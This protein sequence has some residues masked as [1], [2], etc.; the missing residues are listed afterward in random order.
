MPRYSSQEVSSFLFG[1]P[2][3]EA[4][5]RLEDLKKTLPKPERASENAELHERARE[6]ASELSEKTTVRAR[7]CGFPETYDIKPPELP[8]GLTEAHL[9]AI[10]E[11]LA[12]N[13]AGFAERVLPTAADLGGLANLNSGYVKT[14]F[15]ETQRPED[16]ANGLTS[17]RPSWFDATYVASMR[18]ELNALGGSLVLLDTAIKP[19]YKDGSQHYGTPEGNDPAQDPLLPLFREALA[20]PEKP[21]PNRFNHSRDELQNKL[22]PLAKEKIK[23][24]LASRGLPEVDFE[25]ILAPAILD[26]QEMTFNQ[27]LSS[28][29]N[30]WEWTNTPKLDSN[31]TDTGRFLAAGRSGGGGAGFLYGYDRSSG[32][33]YL[34]ARLAVV[35]KKLDTDT[36]A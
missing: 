8:P 34:G 21:T 26:N 6:L 15:P 25:V 27:P 2:P 4:G 24:E 23:A 1:E 30:T 9:A 5:K 18:Q 33:D 32:L 10:R 35:F 7:E 31:N 19:K 17:F 3:S 13:G 12:P 11:A 22:I 14:M 20:M 16:T 36:A 29:T 28:T